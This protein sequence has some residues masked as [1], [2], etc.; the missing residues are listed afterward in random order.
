[1]TVIRDHSCLDCFAPLAM[2]GE[3]SWRATFQVRHYER[4]RLPLVGLPRRF[5]PRNDEDR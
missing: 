2:T 3:R 5:A 1:V 4:R